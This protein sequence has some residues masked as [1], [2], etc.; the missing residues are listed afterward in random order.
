MA[1][2][3]GDEPA[4][5]QFTQILGYVSLN[6]C[7]YSCIKYNQGLAGTAESRKP[8]TTEAETIQETQWNQRSLDS[9]LFL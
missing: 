5:H 7:F 4:S 3:V 8:R 1:G 6:F 9:R 2:G